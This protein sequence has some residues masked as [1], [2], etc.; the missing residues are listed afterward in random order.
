MPDSEQLYDTKGAGTI[1]QELA[2]RMGYGEYF[3]GVSGS[4]WNDEQLRAVGTSW[5][6][7]SNSESNLW[8]REI[9]FEPPETFNTPSGKI[10]MYSSVL[11]DNDFDPLP[12]WQP[13]PAEPSDEYPFYFVISRPAVHN[14]KLAEHND[15]GAGACMSD[16]CAKVYRA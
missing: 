15:P 6:E 4:K 8:S 1:F 12:Y 10:E 7:L 3:E 16:F 13:K 11:R 9:P 2:E 5:E 14:E